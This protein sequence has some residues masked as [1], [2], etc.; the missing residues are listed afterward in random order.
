MGA[1]LRC[2]GV[3]CGQLEM[4]VGGHAGLQL[5]IGVVDIDLDAV[6]ERD[7]LLI[8]LHT[9]GREL[10]VR[11]DERDAPVILL[12][13]I[14]IGGD[15]CVLPPVN[16]AEVRLRDIGAEPDVIEIGERD[17]RSAGRDDFAQ[18]RL[19][20]R[21]DAR[22]RREQRGVTQVDAR[23]AE[24]GVRLGEIGAR[25]GDVFLAAAFNGL[26]VALLS[27]FERGFGALQSGCGKVAVLCGDFIFREELLGAVVIE[28]LLL[29]IGLRVD[30]G[31]L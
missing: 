9:L 28:L 29:Q 16:A 3:G 12:A 25:D 24:I 30:H 8:G 1:A 6:D 14:S 18:F 27:G 7:A 10:G 20:H 19:A 5:V 31:L 26:V 23:E 22:R 2:V 21:N 11:R 13:G 15:G 4:R 17:H